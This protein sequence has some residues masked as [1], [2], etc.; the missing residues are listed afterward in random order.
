MT[1]LGW[2]TV[3]LVLGVLGTLGACCIWA[4]VYVAKLVTTARRPAIY[5][6]G[7]RVRVGDR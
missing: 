7:G 5:D 1:A 3:G 4:G 2:F 6:R